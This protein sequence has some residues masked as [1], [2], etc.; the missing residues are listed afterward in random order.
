MSH[1]VTARRRL[2]QGRGFSTLFRHDFAALIRFAHH[3]QNTQVMPVTW[4]AAAVRSES[5]EQKRCMKSFV[6]FFFV[7]VKNG[8]VHM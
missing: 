2:A 4:C 3:G 1:R 5:R 8:F 6:S 7:F